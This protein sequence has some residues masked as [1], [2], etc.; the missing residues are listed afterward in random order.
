MLIPFSSL[1][2]LTVAH[3]QQ[4]LLLEHGRSSY[5]FWNRQLRSG[6][7]E[8]KRKWGC[9]WNRDILAIVD[10]V[11]SDDNN[12]DKQ[13]GD[14]SLCDQSSSN[15][16]LRGAGRPALQLQLLRAHPGISTLSSLFAYSA[17]PRCLLTAS[18]QAGL[19]IQYVSLWHFKTTYVI[20]ARPR[21]KSE[22]AQ[23]TCAQQKKEPTQQ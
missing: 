22:L 11:S 9:W 1:S 2:F 13:R 16:S 15:S 23:P 8:H 6:A 7:E 17:L 18:N 4:V 5:D 20:I 19:D 10:K 3:P 21:L 14:I 12:T